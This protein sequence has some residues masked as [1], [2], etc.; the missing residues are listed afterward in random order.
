M[1]A[2]VFILIAMLF[3]VSVSYGQDDNCLKF[4]GKNDYVKIPDSPKWAF[5][6]SD[7]TIEFWVKFN[8]I[9]RDQI[10]CFLAQYDTATGDNWGLWMRQTR[11]KKKIAFQSESSGQ[12]KGSFMITKDWL[13]SLDTWYH[14]AFERHG[15]KALFYING[16]S[17][18]VTQVQPWATSVDLSAPLRI[19]I[20]DRD[21]YPLDGCMDEVRI[22][23]Y[24]RN[25]QELDYW[26]NRPITSPQSGL[27]SNWNFNEGGG[28]IAYDSSGYGN[29][30]QILGARWTKYNGPVKIVPEPST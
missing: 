8:V 28:K 22:W 3:F 5:G 29:N 2:I 1:R 7:F 25:Q 4:D 20:Y 12:Q 21:L 30:G 23:N 13:P 26:K 14:L 9:E 17:Q 24:A 18:D 19:G 16:V 15:D 6:D 11:L 10:Y 27:V